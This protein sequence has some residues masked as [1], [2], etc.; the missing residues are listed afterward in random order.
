MLFIE[1]EKGSHLFTNFLSLI[2]TN[3]LLYG[4]YSFDVDHKTY[5]QSDTYV[6]QNVRSFHGYSLVNN[7]LQNLKTN[8][9]PL[10]K[11][12]EQKIIEKHNVIGFLP[13]ILVCTLLSLQTNGVNE[14]RK[15]NSIPSKHLTREI[16]HLSIYKCE[17]Q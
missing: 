10:S 17:R 4:E 14:N 6:K 15:A 8:K 3:I 7:G 16:L 11:G 12:M 1:H 9:A 5:I 2:C 13:Q